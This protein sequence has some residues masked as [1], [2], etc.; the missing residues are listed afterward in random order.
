MKKTILMLLAGLFSASA[1]AQ[2]PEGS[3]AVQRLHPS[4]LAAESDVVVLA[5]LDRLDYQRR[6]GFPVSGNAWIRVL[7]PYKLPRPMDLIRIVEDGFGPDRCYFPDVPLWQ[8]L[9]RYLMFLN[10]VDNRDFEGNRGGCMLEVLVTSDN[11]YAVRWPQDGLVLDEEELELVEE[12]DF[13]GPGATIDVTD[14]TSI[15][16]AALIED[17]YMVDDGDFRFRYTRGIPLEVFRSSIMGRESL[18]TDRQ[19]LGR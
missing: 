8:E 17:Y 14:T 10:E 9:P 11:R 18:T 12:L 7:V 5:Q 15:S 13:I 3:E 2:S 6:R 16:R 19:Q 4:Q 1:F